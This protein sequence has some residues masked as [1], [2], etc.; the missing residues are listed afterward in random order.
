MSENTMPKP[1]VGMG[2]SYGAGSD[3][4]PATIVKVSASGKT[5]W[6]EADDYKFNPKAKEHEDKYLYTRRPGTAQR[7]YT[8]RQDGYFHEVGA[9]RGGTL[10]IGFRRF[11]QDPSF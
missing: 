8:L 9:R 10:G 4:Y 6:I 7:K 2:A 3:S 11:Y 1:E 5:L